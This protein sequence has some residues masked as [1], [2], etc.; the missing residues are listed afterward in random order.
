MVL[1][2]ENT[3]GATNIMAKTF[4][5]FLPDSLVDALENLS[6]SR[7]DRPSRN[8]LISEAVEAF[9]KIPVKVPEAAPVCQFCGQRASKLYIRH[10]DSKVVVCWLHE[11]KVPK[12]TVKAWKNL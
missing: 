7:E 11:R 9:L 8:K 5:V 3:Q 12:A 10:D 4:S 6:K 1:L 2:Y